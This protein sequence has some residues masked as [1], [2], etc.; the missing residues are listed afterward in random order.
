MEREGEEDLCF[1]V[2][3]SVEFVFCE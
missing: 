3:V 2:E 1:L